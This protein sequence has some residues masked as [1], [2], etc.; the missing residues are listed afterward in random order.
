MHGCKDVCTYVPVY[1]SMH[2]CMHVCIFAYVP[3]YASHT[4]VCVQ[5][6]EYLHFVLT[7][8]EPNSPQNKKIHGACGS[9]RP[10]GYLAAAS[11]YASLTRRD[12]LHDIN[13]MMEGKQILRG[14]F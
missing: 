5:Y 13:T 11:K 3:I 10:N 8:T 9:A 7:N 6:I 2:A 4:Y 12:V 14:R 1:V